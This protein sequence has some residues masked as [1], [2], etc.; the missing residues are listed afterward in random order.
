MYNNYSKQVGK[1]MFVSSR[2]E[3]SSARKLLRGDSVCNFI[4]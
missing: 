3:F 1:R 2:R 4:T